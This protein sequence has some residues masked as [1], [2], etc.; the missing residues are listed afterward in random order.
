MSVLEPGDER[1]HYGGTSHCWLSP[2]PGRI[3]DVVWQW[4]VREH[5]AEHQQRVGGELPPQPRSRP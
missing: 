4:M 3:S 1:L 5:L 2:D